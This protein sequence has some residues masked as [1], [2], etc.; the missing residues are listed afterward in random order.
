MIRRRA[1]ALMLAATTVAGA[2]CAPD[3]ADIALANNADAMDHNMVLKA[4]RLESMAEESSNAM[5]DNMM[6]N[7]GVSMNAATLDPQS[8][9][10][11]AAND[12]I[13]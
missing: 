13:R 10:P 12:R 4:D 6:D 11:S 7:A 8:T 3:Q 2:G 1:F 9:L 5:A